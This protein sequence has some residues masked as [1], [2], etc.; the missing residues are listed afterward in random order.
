[1]QAESELLQRRL[2]A[3][4]S[5]VLP[6]VGTLT[7]HIG[8]RLDFEPAASWLPTLP[9]LN[10]SKRQAQPV[11][12]VVADQ[13]AEHRVAVVRVPLHVRRMRAAAA[14]FIIALVGFVLSTPINL[15]RAQNAS[16]A[17]PE[18]TAPEQE[19]V[20]AIA[21]PQDLELA[22]VNAPTDGTFD[23]STRPRLHTQGAYIV[24]VGSFNTMAKANLFIAQ[25]PLSSHLHAL[26]CGSMV[27]IYA[28]SADTPSE[29]M[30]QAQAIPGFRQAYPD[31]W[32]CR[33]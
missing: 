20:E 17:F 15:E 28:A 14:A 5:V 7:R 22:I 21:P 2:K 24:V 12:E 13:N 25:Q 32:P 19:P 31:A 29:A 1:M 33:R 8:G 4:G 10:L 26:K 18:F 30:A 6:Y 27:R 11:L 9:V 16:M 23:M 3:E